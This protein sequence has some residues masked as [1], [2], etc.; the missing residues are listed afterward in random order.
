[1]PG[2][3]S[4]QPPAEVQTLFNAIDSATPERL[5]AILK[6]LSTSVPGAVPFV[7]GELLLKQ[8]ELKR[9]AP[10]ATSGHGVK[11]EVDGHS[12]DDGF[13]DESDYSDGADDTA[14]ASRQRF[15][16]CIQCNNEYN[17]LSNDKRSCIW[18][19]GELEVDHEGDF[20]ADHDERC[21]GTID[22]D[23]MRREYPEGFIWNCCDESGENEGCKKSRHRPNRAKRVKR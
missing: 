15:E 23:E 18:H 20:W 17:V 4:V 10:W 16:I 19:E 3:Q 14:I 7:Q 12:E 5:R 11:D 9:A 6:K 1:M 22:T 2:P 21:H 13:Q 8:G